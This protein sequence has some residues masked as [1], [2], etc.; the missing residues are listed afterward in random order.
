MAKILREDQVRSERCEQFGV[1]C[2]NALAALH[3]FA[4]L[5]VNFRGSGVRVTRGVYQWRFCRSCRRK[6]HS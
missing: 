5:P 2:I 6:S 3:E 4:D 1:H